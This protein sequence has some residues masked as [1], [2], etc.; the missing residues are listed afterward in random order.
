MLVP[1][2]LI[3]FLIRN[4]RKSLRQLIKV[5]IFSSF[6]HLSQRLFFPNREFDQNK[7]SSSELI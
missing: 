3:L 4:G 7:E 5:S 6:D 1:K 2:V